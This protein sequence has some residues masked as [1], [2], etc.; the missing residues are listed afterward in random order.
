M[1]IHPT[2]AAFPMMDDESLAE[3]AADI[4]EN[5]LNRP[6][7]TWRDMIL[8]G[9]NRLKA[10]NMATVRPIYEEWEGD[11][12]TSWIISENL[13]R[14]H[15]TASQRAMVA[16]RLATTDGPGRNWAN[17]PNKDTAKQLNVSERSVKHARKVIDRA[18][19]ALAQA[20]DDGRIAVSRASAMVDTLTPEEQEQAAK[21]PHVANNS[22]NNEWYT[23]PE[24]IEAARACMGG[25]DLDPASSV[26]ANETVKAAKYYT[27]ET[28][29]LS[30]DWEGRVWMNPPYSGKLIK[31][32]AAKLAASAGSGDVTQACVLVNNATE[33]GW[34]ADMMAHASALCLL[35]GRVRFLDPE[36]N[37]SGAPL[38]GQVV[39]Y[40]GP[41]SDL[42][43]DAFV[44][45]GMILVPYE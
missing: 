25:I 5:G 41:N 14:R 28:D 40:M 21:R 24:Y 37:P 4:R 34:F 7:V 19:P 30:Q 36:G 15:L 43:A 2:C 10:C 44:S 33:T 23:P 1:N 22:G 8:D 17:L 26:T 45:L 13:H 39:I 6:I 32:F 29:G 31:R 9:R 16:G 38:Q 20:V 42:F 27:I 11:D 35:D 3:L 12:P 18:A